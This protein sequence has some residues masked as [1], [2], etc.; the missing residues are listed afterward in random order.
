MS[1]DNFCILSCPMY[2]NPDGN[3]LS[4]C[5]GDWKR[6]LGNTQT[7]TIEQIWNSYPIKNYVRLC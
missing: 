5:I 2:V 1:T 3:V 4:C 7:N 6:S